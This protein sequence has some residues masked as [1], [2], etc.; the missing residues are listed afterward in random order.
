VVQVLKVI[1]FRGKP[2]E[3]TPPLIIYQSAVID[4]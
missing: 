4:N 1:R 3:K 2:A